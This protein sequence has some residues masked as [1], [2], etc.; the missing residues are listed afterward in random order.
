MILCLLGTNP[1][2]FS[3]LARA[4]DSIAG[5]YKLHV[6]M[7][8]G[9]TEYAPKYSE[10]FSFIEHS[11]IKDLL[12]DASLV[13]TQGG[14]GSMSDAILLNKPLIAVPRSKELGEA[15]DNQSELVSYYEEK[16]YLKAC[17][18]IDFLENLILN[19]L[20]EKYTFNVFKAE[21]DVKISEYI[22]QFITEHLK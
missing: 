11:K 4:V 8:K 6:V 2:D 5:K 9:Y 16:G 13:I 17:Y 22:T 20:D 7:Q 15:Q 10:A 21:S 19:A 14:F 12:K 18:D 1:Y 3:R